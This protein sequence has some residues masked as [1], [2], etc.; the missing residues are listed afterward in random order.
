MNYLVT[1]RI[2]VSIWSCA[3]THQIIYVPTQALVSAQQNP[4]T[5]SSM[6][7]QADD[8]ERGGREGGRE[9]GRGGREGGTER[10]REEEGGERGNGDP[11]R[12]SSQ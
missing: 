1:R 12:R 3:H 8:V 9:R 6:V 10:G 4:D 11:T 5:H 7:P 2:K